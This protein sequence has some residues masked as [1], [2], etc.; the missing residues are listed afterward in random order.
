MSEF[1]NIRDKLLKF[2]RAQSRPL[3]PK[4]ISKMTG[5]NYNTVRARLAELRKKGLAER[6]QE[7]WIAK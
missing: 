4:E 3:T 1:E 7:G 6:T 5:I 2:L